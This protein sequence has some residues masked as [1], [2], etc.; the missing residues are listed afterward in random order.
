[1]SLGG[2]VTEIIYALGLEEALVGTD[3]SSVYPAAAT[4][5]P[6][7]GY[8]RDLPIEGLIDLAPDVILASEQAGPKQ[9]L[10]RLATLGIRIEIIDDKPTLDSLSKRIGQIATVFGADQQG[11][12]LQEKVRQHTAVSKQSGQPVTALVLMIHSNQT[13]A[14]GANTAPALL[15][16]L[17]GLQN[18]IE[19]QNGYRSIS[20]ESIAAL[21][22][23]VIIL[24]G[25]AT[26]EKTDDVGDEHS[27]PD[28]ADYAGLKLT[29]AARND[30]ITTIDPLLMLSI[31]PRVGESLAL[32]TEL[33]NRALDRA[34]S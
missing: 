10:D 5:L 7:V 11:K 25:S 29:P 2:S 24:T 4:N 8:H 23:D 33:R 17:A 19:Q 15:L 27:D 1:M 16:Q 34:D 18:V 31:G 30:T 6:S 14:A 22:P 28:T 3:L 26:P 21:A 13:Q 20:S 32:L 12:S 9:V